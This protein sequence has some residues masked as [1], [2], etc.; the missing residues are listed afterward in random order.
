DA[1]FVGST[2]QE[3][4]KEG[5]CWIFIKENLKL[6]FYGQYPSE[7]LWR[8]NS[9][10]FIL[11]V[12]GIYIL[13]PNLKYKGWVGSFL[14]ILFPILSVV[15]FS[16]GFGLE[17]VETRLWGGL[18]LTLVIAGVGIVLSLP[19]GVMLAL[20]RRSK[21]PVV[22]LLS[23]I[24][25]EIW[26]GV[27]LITVLFMASNMFP[28]F[29]PEGVNFD[30]LIRALIGVMFFSAAYLA[31]VV[32]GGLQAMPKGQYEAAQAMGLSYWRMMALVILPQSLKMVIPAIIGSFIAIFKDT[33]LVLVIGLFDFLGI[34]QFVGTNPDWLGFSHEGYVFAAA[35]FWIFCFGMS[36]YSQNLEKKLDTGR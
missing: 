7:E 10:Y 32:R 34:I 8:I 13:I 17:T 26:R 25:I 5:A 36:R 6:I 27:P 24:F 23:T 4:S 20:G 15:M 18:F 3:C 12:C 30:K 9:M 2:K 14:L 1:S 33:T 11:L 28:L 35:I 22:S 16:G 21:L 29:M 19:I 31:E